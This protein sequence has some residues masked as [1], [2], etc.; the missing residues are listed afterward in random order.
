MKK[1]LFIL[2]AFAFLF[3]LLACGNSPALFTEK[4]LVIASKETVRI[5]EL[6]L[7]ITNNG[8][9]RKWVSEE[10]QP[11]YERPFCGLVI[12]QGD[13]TLTAGQNFNPVLI[14]NAR[15]QLDKIN[16]WG[17]VEDSV[18]PGGCRVIVTKLQ[19]TYR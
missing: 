6:N 1:D 15:I 4:R 12:K 16:P 8:C 2:P 10:G 14:G 19:G 5:P 7:S 11:A 3:A 13:S 17:V 9:G 18:P